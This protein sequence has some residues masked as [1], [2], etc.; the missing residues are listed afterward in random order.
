MQKS[1]KLIRGDRSGLGFVAA[2]PSGCA[3]PRLRRNAS[4]LLLPARG[5]L[6]GA[7]PGSARGVLG[8]WDGLGAWKESR[9]AGG[10]GVLL[11]RRHVASGAASFGLRRYAQRYRISACIG[12]QSLQENRRLRRVSVSTVH[13][14][15]QIVPSLLFASAGAMCV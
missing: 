5:V 3:S 10:L 14:Q 9:V 15:I 12:L 4:R 11:A 1:I 6:N 7:R 8:S 2:G 13:S